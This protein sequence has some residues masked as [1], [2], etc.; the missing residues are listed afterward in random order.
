MRRFI[1]SLLCVGCVTSLALA[2]YGSIRTKD[3]RMYEGD[4][5]E[6]QEQVQVVRGT[7]QVQVPRAEVSAITYTG[8]TQEVMEQRLSELKPEDMGARLKIG[9]EAF[10]GGYYD[11][12][13]KTANEVLDKDPNSREAVDL[14]ND[15]RRQMLLEARRAANEAAA[16][17]GQVPSVP[18]GDPA[19]AAL[20]KAYLTDEEINLIK[21]AELQPS[22]AGRVRVRLENNVAR[23]YMALPQADPKFWNGDDFDRA[24][25]IIRSG[26]MRLRKDVTIVGDPGSIR[27]YRQNIQRLVLAGCATSSC[28]GSFA[29]GENFVLYPINDNEAAAY[30]NFL[31]LASYH[32]KGPGDDSA[33]FGG[34]SSMRKMIDRLNPSRSLLLQYGLP[35][36]NALS[37]HPTVTPFRFTFANETD[38]QFR[39]VQAW[40]AG[41]LS[42]QEPIYPVTY[43]LPKPQPATTRSATTAVAEP[44]APAAPAPAP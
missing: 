24:L 26:D 36:Q 13:R 41:S 39:R 17:T 2:R 11:L 5:R 20:P 33:V 15:V 37:P 38:P 12:A 14:L 4:V 27:D 32:K 28:H 23:R 22:D 10:R 19:P 3:G 29:G 21:Q 35:V 42:A 34:A 40:I 18:A 9:R 25:I 31:I 8:D 7:I 43:T 16:T 1:L 44:M 6:G 30:T